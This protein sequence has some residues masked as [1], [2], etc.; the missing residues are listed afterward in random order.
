MD[1]VFKTKIFLLTSIRG[2][3][4]LVQVMLNVYIFNEWNTDALLAFF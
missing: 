3:I 2:K 4:G 1:R